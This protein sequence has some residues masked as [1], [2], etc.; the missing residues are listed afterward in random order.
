[1]GA[2]KDGGA[3]VRG[4]C[5]GRNHEIIRTSI[6]ASG[7]VMRVAAVLVLSLLSWLCNAAPLRPVADINRTILTT[8][9]DTSGGRPVQIGGRWIMTLCSGY[10]EC[11]PWVSDGTPENTRALTHAGVS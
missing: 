8:D 3:R 9:P 10:N 5:A 4:A 6:A 2:G 1:M 11:L 7:A